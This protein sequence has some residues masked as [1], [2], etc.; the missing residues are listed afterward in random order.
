MSDKDRMDCL[1]LLSLVSAF[2]KKR[3]KEIKF[4]I[5]WQKKSKRDD[6]KELQRIKDQVLPVYSLDI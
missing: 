5:S 1:S 3:W 6:Q 2:K 4:S